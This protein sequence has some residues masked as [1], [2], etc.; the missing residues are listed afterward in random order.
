DF[1][2][3]RRDVFIVADRTTGKTLLFDFDKVSRWKNT[4]FMIPKIHEFIDHEELAEFI[5]E[6]HHNE[7]G[8][9]E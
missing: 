1:K 9:A 4:K 8:E 2:K 7:Y 5:K 3:E 6:D